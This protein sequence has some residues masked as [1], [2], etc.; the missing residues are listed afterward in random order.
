[1]KKIIALALVFAMLLSATTAFAGIVEIGKGEPEE[2]V[3]DVYIAGEVPNSKLNSKVQFIFL[4]GDDDSAIGNIHETAV[5]SEGKYEYKFKFRG[6]IENYTLTVRDAEGMH[7]ISD[8]IKTATYK[9][10]MIVHDMRVVN[11]G[12]SATIEEGD[13][14][15]VNAVVKNKYDNE[16]FKVKYLLAAYDEHGTLLGIKDGGTID[17]GYFADETKVIDFSSYKMPEGAVKAKVFAWSDMEAMIPVG[18][19][20]SVVSEPVTVHFFGASTTTRSYGEASYPQQGM[21]YDFERYMAS[22]VRVTDY[23]IGGWSLKVLQEVS[24][25]KKPTNPAAKYVYDPDTSLYAQMLADIKPG[26]FVIFGS[27][28]N[29][30]RYQTGFND[31]VEDENGNIIQGYTAKQSVDEYKARLD[32]TVKELLGLGAIPI[33]LTDLGNHTA[34]TYNQNTSASPYVQPQIEVCEENGIDFIDH[35]TPAYEEAKAKGYDYNEFAKRYLMTN[36]AKLWYQE[37]DRLG[38][39]MAK[40]E[41]LAENDYVH[42]TVEGALLFSRGIVSGLKNTDNPINKYFIDK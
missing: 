41:K 2:N 5:D 25:T 10:E 1:M 20:S 14:V 4:K 9:Q 16:N 35:R 31:A 12:E 33:I 21:S 38:S 24:R 8:T 18:A 29:N 7:D 11:N 39:S 42:F 19:S 13:S 28:G 36:A 26:D 15:Y 22:G 17:Y 27:T 30:E 6:D 37:Y 40:P 23:A 3:Y 34:V 32:A